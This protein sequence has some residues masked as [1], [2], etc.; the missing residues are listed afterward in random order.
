MLYDTLEWSLTPV[1]QDTYDF[2][3]QGNEKVVDQKMYAAIAPIVNGNLLSTSWVFDTVALLVRNNIGYH[4]FNMF[5]CGCGDAGCAG[6]HDEVHIRVQSDIVQ[7]QFPRQKPFIET[8]VP[9]HFASVDN[10][11]VWTFEAS[12]YA[13]ALASLVVMIEKLEKETLDLSVELWPQDGRPNNSPT[14]K[15][16]IQLETAKRCFFEYSKKKEDARAYWGSL[17]AASLTIAV[18]DA[19]Y[20]ISVRDFLEVVCDQI[21]E[22]IDD[23]ETDGEL[24]NLRETWQQEQTGYFK[25]RP[26]EFVTLFKS[27]PWEEIKDIG[28]VLNSDSVRI[29]ERIGSLWPNVNACLVPDENP[30]NMDWTKL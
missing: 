20:N 22:K 4:L 11:L 9:A 26:E 18:E 24:D 25:T 10:P 7:W 29:L 28:Y 8:L 6:I 16:L 14:P 23:N 2:D 21:H 17:Y 30:E 27:M 5:T 12:A 1:A 13:S 19:T 15:V 3:E